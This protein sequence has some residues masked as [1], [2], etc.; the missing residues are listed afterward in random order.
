MKGKAS[1]KKNKVGAEKRLEIHGGLNVGIGMKT[2]LHGPVNFAKHRNC[3]F[4]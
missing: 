3:D 4:V 1:V 2:Y